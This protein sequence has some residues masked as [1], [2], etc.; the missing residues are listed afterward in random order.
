LT[1]EIARQVAAGLEVAHAKGIV[2]RDLKPGN[3]RVNADG[4]I[5][6]LDFGLAKAYIGDIGGSAASDLSQSPTMAKAGTRVVFTAV[7]RS[8][9]HR[10]HVRS[11]VEPRSWQLDGTEDAAYPFW[12][13]D[14]R[15]IGFFSHGKLRKVPAAGD[16]P[17]RSSAMRSSAKEVPPLGHGSGLRE[18]PSVVLAHWQTDGPAVQ[19]HQFRVDGRRRRRRL[20]GLYARE[21]AWWPSRDGQQFLVARP[22]EEEPRPLALVLNWTELLKER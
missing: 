3:I 18:R 1:L 7:D 10:F 17:P 4:D 16:E 21:T 2:H 14:S 19:R 12:S 15:V 13:P 11:L 22:R 6:V 20:S 5:K 9:I 8:G